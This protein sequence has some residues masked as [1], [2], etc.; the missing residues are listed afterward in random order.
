MNVRERV[1]AVAS[2]LAVCALASTA[3]ASAHHSSAE[4]YDSSKSVEA[5]GT[6]TRVLFKNPHS[7]VFLESTD[8][9]GQKVEWQVELG[10]FSS[11][12]RAGWTKEMLAPRMVVK[13]AGHRALTASPTRGSPSRTGARS[14]RRGPLSTRLDGSDR[15]ARELRT[16]GVDTRVTVHLGLSHNPHAS[17][18]RSR[19]A[20]GRQCCR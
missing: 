7:F 2:A 6:I 12:T 4:A 5:Q 16:W 17:Y 1:G 11:M 20:R 9:Q 18:R 8:P 15:L 3:P 10:A 14:V 13:V 19:H